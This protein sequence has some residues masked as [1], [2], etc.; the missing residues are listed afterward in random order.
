M[1]MQNNSTKEKKKTMPKVKDG[2][3]WCTIASS[4]AQSR[5]CFVTKTIESSLMT[6]GTYH[7]CSTIL[8]L[9]C[10]FNKSPLIQFN[11]IIC[12]EKFKLLVNP[13]FFS[14][15]LI[16]LKYIKSERT[17]GIRWWLGPI[18]WRVYYYMWFIK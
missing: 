10:P 11:N 15:L 14:I 8:L 2:W 18:F 1:T 13:N 5:V 6:Q 4:Y 3:Q 9:L 12:L 16:Q 17:Q 7:F